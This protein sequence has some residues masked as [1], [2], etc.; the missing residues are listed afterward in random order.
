MT[1]IGH[2]SMEETTATGTSRPPAPIVS[3]RIFSRRAPGAAPKSQSTTASNSA[4]QIQSA[5]LDGHVVLIQVLPQ[6]RCAAS[7]NHA[8]HGWPCSLRG[9]RRMAASH[10]QPR[11][12][13]GGLQL[14]AEK[15][16]V[17]HDTGDAFAHTNVKATWIDNAAD[18]K[19]TPSGHQVM[20]A[21]RP[22]SQGSLAL[23]GR[24]PSHVISSEAELQQATG[25]A[26]FK[27][28]ARLWQQGNSVTAPVIVLD[29]QKQTLVARSTDPAEPVR[30][31]LVSAGGSDLGKAPPIRPTR[32]PATP[33]KENRPPLGNTSARRRFKILRRRTQG[34]D[35]RRRFGSSG[36]R[37]RHGDVRIR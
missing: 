8:R 37:N 35:A 19:P 7:G 17:S 22:A 5:V 9:R 33:R 27:G 16:D 11:V 21:L 31:V 25:V 30:I 14:T 18:T 10:P 36:C 15:I 12:E 13:D 23:G 34:R 4:A 2:A 29:R 26:T 1:G 6:T 24:E 20:P 32:I 28:H 3:K